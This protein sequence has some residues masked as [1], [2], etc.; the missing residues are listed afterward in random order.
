LKSETLKRFV[1]L[2]LIFWLISSGLWAQRY[3][4]SRRWEEKGGTWSIHL[5]VGTSRYMGDLSEDWNLAH[6]QLGATVGASVQYRLSDRFSARL[7]VRAYYLHADQ[8][9]TRTWYNN[10]DF[11]TINPDGWLGLQYDLLH[12]DEHRERIPYVF[13]GGGVTYMTPFTRYDKYLIDLTRLHTEG[14]NYNQYAGIIRYGLGCA[15]RSW[16]RGSMGL[17]VSY[18]HALSDYL[19]DVSGVYPNYNKLEFPFASVLSDRTA[20]IGQPPN[21][22]GAQ[23]GNNRA[24][25][26]YY[27]L[28]VRFCHTLSTYQARRRR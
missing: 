23:R 25:D 10:L 24:N 11:Q 26:G 9:Y 8:K 21:W 12:Q 16:E 22:P 20:E 13:L 3:T 2:L 4:R 19:D 6:L 7:D 5:D 15:V 14:I 18:T 27:L 28:T 17:E 1:G